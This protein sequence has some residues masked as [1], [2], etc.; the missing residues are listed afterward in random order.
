MANHKP[1]DLVRSG[2]GVKGIGL[3]GAVA[4]SIAIPFFFHPATQTASN[5]L[6]STLVDRH[7]APHLVE[8]VVTTALLGRNQAYPNQAWVNARTILATCD[9]NTYLERFR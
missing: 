5:G 1:A 3:M 6:T 2:G 7:G 4:A 8:E 9:W